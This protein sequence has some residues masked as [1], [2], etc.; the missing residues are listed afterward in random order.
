[1]RG[2]ASSRGILSGQVD[3]SHFIDGRLAV[4]SLQPHICFSY[5]QYYAHGLMT[6]LFGVLY[7]KRYFSKKMVGIVKF[8]QPPLV[9]YVLVDVEGSPKVNGSKQHNSHPSS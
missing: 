9:L 4:C 2:K 3:G 6:K 8:G 5:N 1:M 7:V